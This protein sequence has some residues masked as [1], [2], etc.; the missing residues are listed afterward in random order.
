[1]MK[2]SF[3][4]GAMWMVL[5]RQLFYWVKEAEIRLL[6]LLSA[7]VDDGYWGGEAMSHR[8]GAPPQYH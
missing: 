4:V 3:C 1:M 2:K 6:L 8:W 7:V 5:A